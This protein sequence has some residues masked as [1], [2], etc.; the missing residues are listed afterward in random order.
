MPSVHTGNRCALSVYNEA[1]TVDDA[2]LVHSG[3]VDSLHL[4]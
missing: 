4:L 2:M 3:A 1:Y